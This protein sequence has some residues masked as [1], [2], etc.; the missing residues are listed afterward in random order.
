MTAPELDSSSSNALTGR[1]FSEMVNSQQRLALIGAAA[2]FVLTVAKILGGV[3][4]NSYALIADGVE[5]ALDVFGSLL[6]WVGL[7]YAVRQPDA[8]HPFGHGKAEP[9][10]SLL[11]SFGLI[12]AACILA[13]KSIYEI[14]F[15]VA[16]RESPAVFTLVILV[17]VVVIKEGL[18]R[19]VIKV[20]DLLESSASRTDAWHHRLDAMTSL[21]AFIGISISII[22]GTRFAH[23]DD[24]AALV[25]CGIIA[26]NGVRLIR[27]ALGEIMD[28]APTPEVEE[29]VREIAIHV[30]GVRAVE[31]CLVRKTGVQYYVDLHIWVDGEITVT[32][33]HKI[34]HEV[35]AAI[36][37]ADPRMKGVLVHVEPVVIT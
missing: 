25:A 4:G 16:P 14:F 7:R 5:S 2:N 9:L 15:V 6:I 12:A 26:F 37:E 21:V 13:A 27:P 3:L 22:G 34:A 30:N 23:A 33:G 31:K 35:A 17:V 28:E 29:H 18:Y 8:N 32:E 11:V 24:W 19:R 10:S 1:R 36:Q 20:S